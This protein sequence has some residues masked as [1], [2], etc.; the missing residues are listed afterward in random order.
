[1]KSKYFTRPTIYVSHPVR[2]STGDMEAN[3]KKTL[4]DMS[5]VE[6]LF[7]EVD[8][9]I[10]ARGDLVLQ[11]LYDAEELSETVILDADCEIVDNS[12]GWC[13]YRFD[14]SSGAEK[15]RKV[16]I[17][18]G[19]VEGTEHDIMYDI[20]KASYPVIRK[21]FTPI[22]AKTIERFRSA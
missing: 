13:Y 17:Q 2:G 21:T 20:G 18:C 3:C 7:P 9:Y 5:K 1:M 19:L 15:E 16:A 12:H 14:E 22:V 11:I 8:L 6:R 10:P 4:S